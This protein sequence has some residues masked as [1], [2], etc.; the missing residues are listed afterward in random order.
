MPDYTCI[1]N[2]LQEPPRTIS[3]CSDLFYRKPKQF[4]IARPEGPRQSHA[5]QAALV[6]YFEKN[7]LRGKL[8]NR[9]LR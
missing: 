8:D 7:T 6:V 4:V 3:K 1:K 2:P 5:S 9:K